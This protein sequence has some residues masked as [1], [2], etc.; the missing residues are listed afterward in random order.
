MGH[1]DEL[2]RGLAAHGVDVGGA[3]V[4]GVGLV[5]N[6][7]EAERLP[8]TGFVCGGIGQLG[9][10]LL[11]LTG[12]ALTTGDGGDVQLLVGVEV[13]ALQLGHV[14]GEGLVVPVHLVGGG[15]VDV[16]GLHAV[17]GVNGDLTARATGG[18]AILVVE[19]GL[20][21]VLLGGVGYLVDEV[22]PLVAQV[23]GDESC[24]GVHEVTA[25]AHLLHDVRLTNQ[26]LA[27]KL[28]VPGPE[29][30]AAVFH[31]GGNKRL[32]DLLGIHVFLLSYNRG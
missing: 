2:I 16:K 22:K 8:L 32:L 11:D 29:G 21:A 6:D 26:L 3:I 9:D 23:L 1:L 24:A 14:Q 31:R 5:G 10:G 7:G 4:V 28:A 15:L 18:P 17:L 27:A 30:L 20:H 19:P 25:Q 12:G 13:D